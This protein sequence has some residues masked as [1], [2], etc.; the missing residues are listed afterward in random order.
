MLKV[1][2]KIMALVVSGTFFATISNEVIVSAKG[3]FDLFNKN[4]VT[5]WNNNPQVFEVNREKA[6]A[7]FV[8]FG[9]SEIA[10]EDAK[11]EIGQNGLKVDSEYYKLLNGQWD[12][13]LVDKPSKAPKDFFENDFDTSEWDKI[14]VPSNWQTEGYDYPIYTNVTYPW[15]GREN[16]EAPNAPTEYNPVGSY[17]R[18]FTV[19]ENWNNNGRRVYV[20]F[21]GVE[22]A[23][24]LWINGQKVG[25]SEDSY[26]AKDFDI[27]DFL[28]EGENTIA[29]QVYR[30]SDGSWLE[31]Q[32]FIRLSGIFRDVAI[33][34]TP[35]VRIRDFEVKTN[36]DETFTDA[37]LELEVNLAN[38]KKSLEEYS[39]EAMLYDEN[40]EQILDEPVTMSTN[41]ENAEELNEKATEAVLKGSVQVKNPKKWSAEN[42]NLYTLIITLKDKE[43]NEF[44]ATN[45]KVGFREFYLEDGQM[46]LNGQPIMFKGTNRHETDPTDGRA[47][48]VESMITDIELMKANNVN[49]VR[50]SHY[51][52]D[53]TWL[54]LCNEYGLYVIDEANLESHGARNYLPAS[55]ADWTEAC[56]DRVKSMVERDKNNPSVL[57]WS[58]GNEAGEGSNFKKMSEWVK[59]NDDT[60]LVHYEASYSDPTVSD[61]YSHMYWS[62]DAVEDYGK[63]GQKK[64]MILCEYAHAMGNSLGNLDQYWEVFEKYE[65]LQGG[66]IWDWVDQALYKET[67]TGDKYLAYGGDWGDNPNDDNFCANGLVT[68]D[69]KAKP[70]L[71]ELK[72]NYQNI[73]IN[74][75]DVA[76]GLILIENEN[77]FTNL[78]EYDLVWEL[79]K[80]NE[81]IE[82]GNMVLDIEPLT[83]K[84]VEIPF[85]K[86]EIIDNGSE[87]WLN[88]SFK[89]KENEKWA[90]AGHEIAYEQIAIKF[91]DDIK[92]KIDITKMPP[93]TTEED[94]LNIRVKGKEF[95]VNFNKEKGNIDSFI[96][97]D[98][99][100]LSTPIEPDFWRAPT[101]N[102]RGN[103]MP[104]R[105][106]MWRDAGKNRTVKNVEVSSEEGIVTIEV[107]ANLPTEYTSEY[108][109]LIKIYGNGD[110][111]ITSSLNPGEFLPEIPAI[112]MEFNMPSEFENLS[113]Y[114]RGPHENYWDRQKSARVGMYESTVE[115]QFFP[116]IE[117]SEMGNKTDVRWMTLTNNEGLG[118]MVSGDPTMEFSALH[119]TEEELESK[120][121]PHELEKSEDVVVNLNYKQ[122]GVGGDDSWGAKP[123]PEFNLYADRNYN[124][125]MRLKP[126]DLQKEKPMDIN[127]LALAYEIKENQSVDIRTFVGNVPTLP[128]EVELEL[129]DK[130]TK[131]F[132][133]EWNDINEDLCNEVGTFQVEGKVVGEDVKIVANII[134][135]DYEKLQSVDVQTLIGEN[136]VMPKII[137]IKYTD[138]DS[139][140]AEVSWDDINEENLTEEGSFKVK[141]KAKLDN[142]ELDVVANVKV[143]KGDYLSNLEWV[144][145]SAGWG[146]VRRDLSVL[147]NPISLSDGINSIVYKK[148]L[149]AH[150]DSTVIYNVEGKDYKYFE[151]YVGLD[152]EMRNGSS[153]GIRFKVLLDEEIAFDSGVMIAKTPSKFIR[154]DIEG[155]KE[156]KLL[157]DKVGHTTNDHGDW[158]N[159]MF[160]K[161]VNVIPSADLNNNGT[162]DIGD[163]SLVSKY[164]GKNSVDNFDIW[165]SVKHFDLNKDNKIDSYEID[166]I[167]E[168]ILE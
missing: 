27:T 84:E 61:I 145:S 165:D 45:S 50:T 138:G 13:K 6:H 112:G 118:L 100:L 107:D 126:I 47:V 83:K 85:N 35:D 95:E 66:F 108:K 121:H 133:I 164:Y 34:S 140:L 24:Y 155:V 86:P 42:P 15:T 157:I 114:G 99:E 91:N 161:E 51:P 10:L 52:N 53:P 110:V 32:D 49:S 98:N 31:D 17:K 63:S 33:Y 68:A 26:T 153:D 111:A 162:I 123:H 167:T 76:N 136:P 144:S 142:S 18:T 102:D 4:E 2:K 19:P 28:V 67:E 77:L 141:G 72:Y 104:N 132:N 82:L 139:E 23:F 105:Q 154:L 55:N 93:L 73:E 30:W 25:Y 80:D 109:N 166:F 48:S 70:Q 116:Y 1:N 65:N 41:F 75:I 90:E 40:Y 151:S 125:R 96:Y 46:K 103:G 54:Q 135:R 62:P 57:I 3:I 134:V 149:G 39:V 146:S 137:E 115:D 129:N 11:K 12:F 7:S 131:I 38:Y 147:R 78:N 29:V 124:Y 120:K 59:E 159:A 9:N 69:R 56:I 117:P 79:K 150:A 92:D 97:N 14:K 22:S 101:D 8:S 148:G 89:S 158:A 119:Y 156:V 113:W 44:E 143:A 128:K 122:M 88:I 20:S 160:T 163:L 87:Y 168:K 94:D 16:P 130:S 106:G 21:Q 74:D 36:L 43:G 71:E 5:E 81:T 127:K 37:N 152:Q 60:R 64:P 58:L